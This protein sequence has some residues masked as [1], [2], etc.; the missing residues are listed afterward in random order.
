MSIRLKI[1]LYQVR[2]GDHAAEHARRPPTSRSSASTTTST[3]PGWRAQQMDTVI[4]L[5]AHMNRYSENIAELL[6]LGRTELDDFY[7]ARSSLEDGL[8]PLTRAGRATRSTSSGPT[9]SARRRPRSWRASARM[10]ELFES[11]DLTAQRLLFLRD[12]GRQ[13]EAVALFREEIE[14]RLDAEL[15]DHIAAAIADEE[16][17]LR[18]IEDRTNQL[19]QPADAAGR[20]RHASR[21]S[22]VSGVAGALLDPGADPPDP[23]A[24][25]R[26]PGRSARATS[27]TA[28]TTT[29]R[30]SSPTS[31]EQFNTTAARLEA[32]RR[33]LLEVQAGLE[34]EVARRTSQLED[35]NG[36]LQRLDHMRMLFL[37]DIGHELRTPADRAA[38][39]GRG[40][41][42]RREAGRGA[43]RDPAA[44]RAAR[45]ADGPAGRGPAVPRPRRGRRRPLRDAADRPAGR[46]RRR[47]RRGAGAGRGRRAPAARRSCRRSR[48]WSR[49]TPSG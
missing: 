28:S 38:R 25:R 45:P 6:L 7:A 23:R 35:A 20:R 37:A 27:A 3:G 14:E 31:R 46:A 30:T 5:S 10:R 1:I 26:A 21:R 39:R 24:D 40:G 47:A 32:Q 29:A 48:A 44:H 15:E 33:K 9:R 19:E 16:E 18:Q 42:A 2:R 8:A 22:L 4:R 11:I 43:S 12:Q 17:E 13:E 49:A 36:R 34:D 41:A